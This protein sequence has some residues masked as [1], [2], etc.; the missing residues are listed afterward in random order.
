MRLVLFLAE[1][2]ANLSP[3]SAPHASVAYMFVLQNAVKPATYGKKRRELIPPQS[4]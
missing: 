1:K 3:Q 4:F 2:T